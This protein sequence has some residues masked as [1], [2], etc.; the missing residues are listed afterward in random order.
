MD[1]EMIVTTEFLDKNNI[2]EIPDVCNE[3]GE[4]LLTYLVM[5]RA[6]QEVCHLYKVFRYNHD[7]LLKEYNF[8][9]S[10]NFVRKTRNN[11]YDDFISINALTMNYI[12]SSKVLISAMENYEK[13][14]TKQEKTEF[15]EKFIEKEYDKYFSYRLMDMVRNCSQHG[16]L[17]VSTQDNK[18]SFDIEQML[19]L[20]HFNYKKSFKQE[21]LR[22]IDEVAQKYKTPFKI[23]YMYC[24][25]EYNYVVSDLYYEFWGHIK[26]YIKEISIKLNEILER[27]PQ[28]YL[29]EVIGFRYDG[30]EHLIVGDTDIMGFV[31]KCK[32]E[33]NEIRKMEQKEWF[34]IRKKFKE[35]KK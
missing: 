14:F 6:L 30:S 29:G 9:I 5:D 16:T 12:S 25:P 18:V 7:T 4:W 32:E 19:N 10:D 13:L 34:S 31:K 20:I 22:L 24:I 23:S 28:L 3:D 2:E 8:F 1:T 35:S 15:K 17:P 21:L 27:N 33:A 26:K 11:Q